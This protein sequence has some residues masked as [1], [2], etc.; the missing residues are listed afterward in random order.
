MKKKFKVT[1][2]YSDLA[3]FRKVFIVEAE[4]ENEV[5]DLIDEGDI[6][7]EIL[8]DEIYDQQNDSS[9]NDIESVIQI[10]ES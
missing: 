10:E 7:F 2:V 6:D 8:S 4:D 3:F 1:Q 5:Y 9:W